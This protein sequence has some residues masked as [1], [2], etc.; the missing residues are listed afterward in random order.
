MA[1]WN[2]SRNWQ[3]V[4]DRWTFRQF[5]NLNAGYA[6]AWG[7]MFHVYPLGGKIW[8]GTPEAV[9]AWRKALTVAAAAPGETPGED[10]I[11]WVNDDRYC[12]FFPISPEGHYLASGWNR[13]I[14][15]ALWSSQVRFDAY[16]P[17]DLFHPDFN[18]PRI[19]LMGNAMTLSPETISRIRKRFLK[20]GR[21]IVWTGAP[22]SLSGAP[23]ADIS[24]AVGFALSRPPEIADKSVIVSPERKPPLLAGVSGFLFAPPLHGEVLHFA[25]TAAAAGP[26][27]EVLG[28]FQGTRHPGMV[29]RKTKEGTEIFIGQQGAL[30]PRLLRNIAKAAGIRPVTEGNDLMIRGGGLIVLGASAGNGV[31]RVFF[32][33]GVEG[34][35]CLTD[36][37]IAKRGKD[38]IDIELKY[39]E[40]AVFRHKG[41]KK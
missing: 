19:L 8:Y 33:A 38:F 3:A 32:P 34:L 5:L 9:D 10:A 6:A 15:A 20:E 27:V 2:R 17:Q 12:D 35:T 31:R 26:G 25:N 37:K 21:I 11:A 22:G 13:N 39:G 29:M 24:R 23:L 7:G 28:Y 18:A 36:Q 14:C 30:T 40:C 4:H 41:G 1:W 16:L